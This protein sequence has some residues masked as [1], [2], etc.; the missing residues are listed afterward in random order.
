MATSPQQRT[1][2]IVY[3]IIIFLIGLSLFNVFGSPYK[4]DAKEVPLSEITAA[5]TDSRVDKIEVDK[6]KVTAQLK[7]G[8]KLKS[9]KEAGVGI[10]EYGITPDKVNIDIK[11][12]SNGTLW[13]TLL[14]VVLP[15]I[16]LAVFIWLIMRQAQGANT[17]AMG[18]GKSSARLA[19]NGRKKVTF[20]DVAGLYEAKQELVEVVDFL[21]NP[22]KYRRIGA[23]IPKGVL[24]VGAPGVGKTLLAKAV[25]GEAGV[26]FFSLS[27]SEFVEMFVGVGAARVRDLF[28]KAKRNAPTVIFVDELDAIGRQRGTG[29]G[30]GHDE[31]EQ[32]LNQI[33]VEMDGFETDARV[34]VLAAT[35]RPDVLDPALLRPGR[36]DRRVVLA[37]PDKKERLEILKLHSA[38]KPVEKGIDLAKVAGSTAGM[39]GADLRNVVNEAAILA[40][41]DNSRT[42]SQKDFNRAIEKVLLGPERKNRILSEQERKITAYH[43]AG[44]AIVGKILQHTDPVH[45]ISIISRGMALGYTWSIPE[46][47]KYLLNKD[48]FNDTIA[49]LLGG[50]AAEE[51]IFG[52]A[53]TGSSNDLE[54]ATKI[55]RDMIKVYGMSE[56]LGPVKLGEKDELVFL[57]RELGEHKTYS[58]DVAK[59]IDE[60][61]KSLIVG[62]EKRASVTLK[63]YQKVLN[64]LAEL[65]VKQETV[66]RVE[67]DALF[68]TAK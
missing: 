56:K 55:A 16:L 51:I 66:E 62:A 65:L 67:F 43:E 13:P 28:Q 50:R 20:K 58:E 44:H 34:I 17:R 12:P 3:I 41:R 26:P 2:Q 63:K 48:Q 1:R 5:L 15:F 54:H 22:E 40:A 35:N 19:G 68:G 36:F 14:S 21:K 7:D 52:Q 33:L 18:F 8:S 23:E 11:N 4:K 31:R 47:D 60:E 39:S 32:T 49:Q 45:K 37:M 53:T 27:A 9:F 59:A 61:I 38:N 57:G 42:V 10:N 30:G 29:L 6:D 25:A 24:L 46:E 64:K